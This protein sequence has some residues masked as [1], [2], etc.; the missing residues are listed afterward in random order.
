M[1]SGHGERNGP[2]FAFPTARPSAV[3]PNGFLE[4]A[5]PCQ[6]HWTT[7]R[8]QATFVPPNK[9]GDNGFIFLLSGYFISTLF[10]TSKAFFVLE[11]FFLILIMRFFKINY[12]CEI[13]ILFNSC[14][15]KQALC[16]VSI[17]GFFCTPSN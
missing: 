15:S 7:T 2:A 17:V 3:L 16:F 8:R 4:L 5:P 1:S 14:V 9:L 11:E 10:A 13:P 12:F 6:S